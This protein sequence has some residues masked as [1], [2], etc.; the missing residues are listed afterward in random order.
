MRRSVRLALV[1]GGLLAGGLGSLVAIGLSEAVADPTERT[2]SI[3]LPGL[4]VRAAPY[5]VAV[6]SDIHIG[7]RAMGSE[8]LAQIVDQVNAEQ[9]DL[10]VILGDFVNGKHGRMDSDPQD[11]IAPLADLKAPDGVVATLGNHDHWTDPDAVQRALEEAGV[12]VMTNR[13]AS[14]GPLLLLGLDDGYTGH[15]NIPAAL[16]DARG[17]PG[18]PV[19]ITHSPDLAPQLPAEVALLL[20]GHTHCG[21]VVL[22][23]L[24]SLAPLLGYHVYNPRYQCGI[25]HDSARSVV[26]T[27]GL[28]SGSIPL[29]IGAEPDWWLLRLTAP[30]EPVSLKR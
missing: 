13:A 2:A 21:Q 11:L 15:A 30:R 23:G 12:T 16:A 29:R 17:K 8:R 10:V 14:A 24:G 18:V 22:P 27:A 28:G 4:P 7:N 25:V 5:K 9:P 6:L 1:A 26:V 20:A 19:A 3:T